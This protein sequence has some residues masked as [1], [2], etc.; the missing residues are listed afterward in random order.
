MKKCVRDKMQQLFDVIV[1][2]AEHNEAFAKKLEDIFLTRPCP[3][4]VP[5]FSTAVSAGSKVEVKKIKSAAGEVGVIIDTKR[6]GR[7]VTG[8]SDLGKNGAVPLVEV[9]VTGINDVDSSI[10][11]RNGNKKAPKKHKVLIESTTSRPANRRDKAVLDPIKL[12]EE[13]DVDLRRKLEDLSEKELKDIIADYGMDTSKLAMK[14]KDTERLIDLIMDVSA[15]RATKGD[16]FR[17]S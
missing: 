3:Q 4:K 5:R 9:A 16:A 6:V 14:W 7:T 13:G 17:D 15:R 12:M 2:E 11:K 8:A 10:K 1:D